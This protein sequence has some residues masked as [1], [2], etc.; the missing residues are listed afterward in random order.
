MRRSIVYRMLAA[1]LAGLGAILNPAVP[2]ENVARRRAPVTHALAVNVTQLMILTL[3]LRG[4]Y[5][6]VQWATP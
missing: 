3:L 1:I 2:W 5:A 4:V 6:L